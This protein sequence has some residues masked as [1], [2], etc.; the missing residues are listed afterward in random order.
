VLVRWAFAR[1]ILLFV[2]KPNRV[3]SAR[4]HAPSSCT[5]AL[6][7]ASVGVESSQKVGVESSQKLAIDVSCLDGFI[8][9]MLGME[10]TL[11]A[12]INPDREMLRDGEGRWTPPW[13]Y[14]GG[15]SDLDYEEMEFDVLA[16]HLLSM[17][18]NGIW[19][20]GPHVGI[21]EGGLPAES[22]E[23]RHP[24]MDR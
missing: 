4:T 17:T 6:E 24:R 2:A 5:R 3:V 16:D 21:W 1:K 13:H 9:E 14:N 11:L 23:P 8:G 15:D 12:R 10:K 20:N 7:A 19:E 22:F 18:H